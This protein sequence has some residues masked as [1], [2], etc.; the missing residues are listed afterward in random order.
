MPLEDAKYVFYQ[1]VDAVYVLHLNGI[2]HC[3]IKPGNILI[4]S[5]LKVRSVLSIIMVASIDDNA[6][7]QT[8]RFWQRATQT[9]P[10]GLQLLRLSPLLFGPLV[11]LWYQG[12]HSPRDHQV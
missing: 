11:V 1:L 2:T 7:G 10:R 5:N 4:D 3:D 6:I 12:V 8:D 9:R